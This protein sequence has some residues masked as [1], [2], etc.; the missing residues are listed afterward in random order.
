MANV[1][2]RGADRRTAE[3]GALIEAAA[4]VFSETG[5][6]G[7]RLGDIAVRAGAA[8]AGTAA[9]G[10]APGTAA[11]GAAP[12]AAPA[13]APADSGEGDAGSRTDAE[14]A[15]KRR[16][17]S[18]L[19]VTQRERVF[20]VYARGGRAPGGAVERLLAIMDEMTGLITSDPIVRAGV[21]LAQS[22]VEEVRAE[23]RIPFEEWALLLRRLIREGIAEG[24][25]SPEIDEDLVVEI[26]NELMVGAQVCSEIE[27]LWVSLP[28]RTQRLRPFIVRL[29][30]GDVVGQESVR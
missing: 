8:A 13:G 11:A 29:L 28:E 30:R 26:I 25:V 10:A 21:R 6:E 20:G 3:R 27:D 23:A 9:A 18:E 22:G 19:L 12:G 14:F 4:E 2:Q 24:E 15:S 7:A 5:F 16:L 1:E 17:V